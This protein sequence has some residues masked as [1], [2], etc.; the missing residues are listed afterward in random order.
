MKNVQNGQKKYPKGIMIISFILLLTFV[1]PLMIHGFALGLNYHVKH[2]SQEDKI[3]KMQ[4]PYF[5]KLNIKTV[6]DF[7]KDA[8]M[9]VEKLKI[10]PSIAHKGIDAFIVLVLL[11]G[12]WGLKNWGRLGIIVF[13]IMR[14]FSG[15]YFL[16][17]HRH[18]YNAQFLGITA[19]VLFYL[20]LIYYFTRPK[21]KEQ[22]K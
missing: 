17:L 4:M 2:M 21:V 3:K 11:F 8:A 16:L 9:R 15:I 7:D 20:F 12:L 6:D 5:K 1:L 19:P 18:Y 14:V 13:L 22:F 10:H